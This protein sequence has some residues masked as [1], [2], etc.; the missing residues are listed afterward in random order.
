[1]PGIEAL[2]MNL[3]AGRILLRW[4]SG[5]AATVNA[6]ASD[7]EIERAVRDAIKLPPVTLIPDKPT[8]AGVTVPSASPAQ[9]SAGPAM[10]NPASV[11][12]TVKALMDEH[13]K[14]MGEIHAAQLEILRSNLV[15]QRTS[16]SSDRRP[17]GARGKRGK[18]GSP[19]I[20]GARKA[21]HI[22]VSGKIRRRN[23]KSLSLTGVITRG[24]RQRSMRNASTIWQSGRINM[25]MCGK[26]ASSR[27]SRAPI[28]RP[29]W[30][31]PKQRAGLPL[32]RAIRSRAS[33]RSSILAGPARGPMPCR[34]GL[35]NSSARKSTCSITTPPKAS[36]GYAGDASSHGER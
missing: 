7:F 6:S 2:T 26:A 22:S 16:V 11:G 19:G 33:W 28:T 35:L 34:S 23:R 3:E 13:I 31:K 27:W 20:R 24:F 21:R 9:P 8:N 17:D 36:Q 18:S 30:R 32:S 29:A 10:T 15:Q 1:V 25:T 14:M 4:G 12:H 5:Y